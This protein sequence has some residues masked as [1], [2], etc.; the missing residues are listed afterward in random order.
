LGKR[1]ENH[2]DLEV[3]DEQ[4]NGALTLNKR[5]D[6]WGTWDLIGPSSMPSGREALPS[7]QAKGR[8]AAMV[9]AQSPS[10]NGSMAARS[11]LRGTHVLASGP[12]AAPLPLLSPVAIRR[13]DVDPCFS[14]VRHKEREGREKNEG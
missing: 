5:E 9:Q 8:S 10:Q 1:K 3:E 7:T 6:K 2:L 4:C 11:S 12:T 13:P 14:V